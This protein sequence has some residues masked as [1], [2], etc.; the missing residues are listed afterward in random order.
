M[1]EY[2]KNPAIREYETKKGVKKYMFQIYTGINPAT[3]KKTTTT[4][5]GF[6]T[7]ALANAVYRK[8][9]AEVMNKKY[10]FSAPLESDALTFNDV[11]Q[12]WF[13]DS[14]RKTVQS[15]TVYKTKQIFDCHILP[16]IGKMN[17]DSITPD[18][19]QPIVNRWA[20]KY[21]KLNIVSRYAN[22]VFK[23]AYTI[24]LIKSNPFN[25]V[26]LPARQVNNTNKTPSTN[27]FSADELDKFTRF[28][29]KGRANGTVSMMHAVYFITMAYT[30]L[31]KG[32]L[33]ALEWSDIDLE[34]NKLDVNKTLAMNEFG[35]L[36][37]QP[38]KWLSYRTIDINNLV[39]N[40]LQEYKGFSHSNLVFPSEKDTWLNL[41]KPNNWLDSIID[42][43]AETFKTTFQLTGDDYYKTFVHRITP[44]GLR[45]T[46]A[47]WLFE[48]DN[49]ITPKA[50]QERL[51]HKNISV[52]MDIY[53]HVTSN[54]KDKLKSALDV[55][56]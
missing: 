10:E 19:L 55:D 26:L 8:I 33:L 50:V 34:D 49:T 31:R 7:P 24:K 16:E 3:N 43:G 12:R 2:K 39:A 13:T 35:K 28:L 48:K 47:T 6:K 27:F 21:A 51:G 45:H 46:H 44:H 23:Y 30:G 29:V 25:H 22:R 36:A 52:T 17:M 42:Q 4:R 18:I 53:T 40:T 32:E 56:Y 37:T 1:F 14:Y 20:T 54:Q 38:P 5:R 11:Y 15:S 41:G 9:E